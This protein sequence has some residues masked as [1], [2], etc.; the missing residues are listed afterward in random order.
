MLPICQIVL[1]ELEDSVKQKHRA[2]TF[3]CKYC[4]FLQILAIP[5]FNS[6]IVKGLSVR[7]S[8][9]YRNS[10]WT[11]SCI[12]SG[13]STYGHG[14]CVLIFPCSMDWSPLLY[15]YLLQAIHLKTMWFVQ[16][17][18]WSPFQQHGTFPYY[19][20]RGVCINWT[21]KLLP[22]LP[23]L[24]AAFDCFF[25][26]KQDSIC[27]TFS[28][29]LFCVFVSIFPWV[30]PLLCKV[31]YL[32]VSP[33]VHMFRIFMWLFLEISFWAALWMVLSMGS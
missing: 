16:S 20:A 23:F 22:G 21:N 5:S 30:L 19:T 13:E 33:A 24:K 18:C 31:F 12:S 4:L 8:E 11:V 25:F 1:K 32:L 2:I 27:C 14:V 15:P 26:L 17:F 7:S 10:N 29:T 6:P 28:D 9:R 3:C